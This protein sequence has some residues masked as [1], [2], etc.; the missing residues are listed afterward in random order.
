MFAFSKFKYIILVNSQENI[1]KNLKLATI[2]TGLVLISLTNIVNT[3]EFKDTKKDDGT[4][5]K[6]KRKEI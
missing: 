1:C 4:P 6:K 5:I 3:K 2:I